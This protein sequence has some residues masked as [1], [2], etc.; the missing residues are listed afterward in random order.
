MH[1]CT[2]QENSTE[3]DEKIKSFSLLE[4]NQN[5]NQ[6]MIHLQEACLNMLSNPLVALQY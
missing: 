6:L 2:S 4:Q 5:D 3:E 1:A